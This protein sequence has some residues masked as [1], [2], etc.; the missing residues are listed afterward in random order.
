MSSEPLLVVLA[1]GAGRRLGEVKALCDLAGRSALEHVLRAGLLGDVEAVVVLGAEALRV[2][3]RIDGKVPILINSHWEAGRTGSLRLAAQTYP[4]RDLLVAPVDVPLV[5]A[6]TH[7]LLRRAW[8]QAGAPP[9]GWL[10]PGLRTSGRTSPRQK[11]GNQQGGAREQ[12]AGRNPGSS[13]A[14]GAAP[15]S[16]AG[17]LPGS[18][19]LPLQP[20]HPVLIGRDLA[21]R[22]LGFGPDQPL[23]ELRGGAQPMW[24]VEVEDVAVID[25]LDTPGDA[26]ALRA[27]L[28]NSSRG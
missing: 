13:K 14:S 26:L 5:S 10:A 25:D 1:A 18:P 27:R 17:G 8:V 23:R 3:E 12:E 20:G 2:Q 22:L 15:A 19:T 6:Q 16:G 11:R 21:R 28:E 7:E 24:M 9:Q 4:G